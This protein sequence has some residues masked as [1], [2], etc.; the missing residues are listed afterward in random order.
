MSE[1]AF[2]KGKIRRW[3]CSAGVAADQF[4]GLPLRLEQIDGAL[5]NAKLMVRFGKENAGEFGKIGCPLQ[6]PGGFR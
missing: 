1:Q 6:A 2:A 5:Q 4:E 3:C